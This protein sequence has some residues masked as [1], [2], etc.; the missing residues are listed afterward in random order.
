VGE[1]MREKFILIITHGRFGIELLRSVEMIIGEQENVV[2]L[3]L[4]P[5]ESVDDLKNI[6]E[7]LIINNQ[8]LNKDII[9]FVDIL[10]G[11]PSNISLYLMKKYKNIKLISGVNMFMLIE[12]L[13]SRELY[14]LDE[15]IDQIINSGN[16]G[17]LKLENN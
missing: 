6:A 9:I 15:L 16:Q 17:I 1:G 11:S 2:A 10:G 7:V 3:E 8:N 5:G 12:A 4:N 13:Q 14:E